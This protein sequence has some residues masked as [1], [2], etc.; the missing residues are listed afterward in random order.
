[1]TRVLAVVDGLNLFHSIQQLDDGLTQ[2]DLVALVD[3]L[4]AKSKQKII[5]VGYFTSIVKH[6]GNS[7]RVLQEHYLNALA[8][9]GAN[10]ELGEFKSRKNTCI[11]C[12]QSYWV[13]VEKQTDVAIASY[14]TQRVF[15]RDFDEILFF[16]AD[17]DFLP[18]LRM[19]NEHKP[20]IR[21]KV[22]STA[23]YLRPL[24]GELSK[25]GMSTIR[26]SRELLAKF[27]LLP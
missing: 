26:L 2:P 22:I 13:Q 24:H 14:L 7:K 21:L 17:T 6:Q 18:A 16:S 23:K 12:G 11:Y 10:I 1:M 8:K 25:A 4:S 9:T 3:F 19:I 5:E 15:T 20:H 27:Q